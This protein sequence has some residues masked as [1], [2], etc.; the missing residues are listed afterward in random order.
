MRLRIDR[1][2][3][4]AAL[5][6]AALLLA[7][8]GCSKGEDQQQPTQRPVAPSGA[9][10]S[11]APQGGHDDLMNCDMSQDMSKMSAE[12]HRQMM[13]RCQKQEGNS[14]Q[15]EKQPHEHPGG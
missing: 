7:S 13:E 6:A 4:T 3:Y 10:P 5:A 9:P 2:R 14:P 1:R 15:S 12:E 11:A 8:V